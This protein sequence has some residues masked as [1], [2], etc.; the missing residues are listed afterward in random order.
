MTRAVITGVLLSALLLCP[1]ALSK[2]NRAVAYA[3]RTWQMQDGLPEQTVQAFA[4]T[5]NRYLWI[6]TT[7]GLLRFDGARFVLYDRDNTPAF[8]ENNI[9]SL[10]VDRDDSLW[11][12]TEGGGL[13]RY[14]DR[15]FCSFASSDGLTNGFVRAVYQDHKGQ[16]WIGTDNGLFRMLGE[17]IERVDDTDHLP[18]IAVHAI[19]EDHLGRLWIGGSRLVCLIGNTSLDY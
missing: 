6:G 4:Q 13:I 16:V 12:G 2:D 18:A 19:H 7:G 8:S 3:A 14:R 11:I 9:F 1:F 5:R 17:R 10:T 15:A